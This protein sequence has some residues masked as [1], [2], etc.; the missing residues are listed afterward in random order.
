VKIERSFY[1]V[2]IDINT[3]DVSKMLLEKLKESFGDPKEV[4]IFFD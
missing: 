3:F 1:T 2:A 4:S